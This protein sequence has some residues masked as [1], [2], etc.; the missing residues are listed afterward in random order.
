MRKQRVCTTLAAALWAVSVTSMFWAFNDQDREGLFELAN[1]IAL[2][3]C[4]PSF[5][6]VADYLF[7]KHYRKIARDHDEL[8]GDLCEIVGRADADRGLARIDRR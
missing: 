3:A 6:L 4:V 5:Y 7:R 1:M 8:L 2:V